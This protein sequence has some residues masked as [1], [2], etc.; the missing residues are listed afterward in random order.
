MSRRSNRRGCNADACSTA[1]KKTFDSRR[2]MK[3]RHSDFKP[4]LAKRFLTQCC[5]FI[6]ANVGDDRNSGETRDCPLQTFA[7]LERRLGKFTTVGF[8][9]KEC[10]T[11]GHIVEIRYMSDI[12]RSDP[13]NFTN[14]V[15]A[16][17]N[18]VVRGD[19]IV[20]LEGVIE[21]VIDK[22]RQ[23]NQPW[24]IRAAGLAARTTP[25]EGANAGFEINTYLGKM[26]LITSGQAKGSRAFIMDDFY[27]PDGNIIPGAV[28]MSEWANGPFGEP[29]G[30]GFLFPSGPPAPGDTFQVLDFYQF[31]LGN[32]VVG[33]HPE[34]SAVGQ[35]PSGEFF[36]IPGGLLFQEVHSRDSL[37][38][39]LADFENASAS[40]CDLS[41]APSFPQGIGNTSTVGG[42]VD[43]IIDT[44]ISVPPTSNA[45]SFNTLFRGS[46]T[47]NSGGILTLGMGGFLNYHSE[48]YPGGMFVQ[49]GGRVYMDGDPVFMG[50]IERV[51]GEGNPS[52]L[53]ADIQNHG[54]ITTGPI[55]FWNTNHGMVA[56]GGGY[57]AFE[58]F[59]PLYGESG[60][61]PFWG[62]NNLQI[63]L[64]PHGE[65]YIDQFLD[66]CGPSVIPTFEAGAFGT[67]PF[68]PILAFLG[69]R[70]EFGWAIDPDTQLPVSPPGGI[71]T[72][73]ADLLIPIPAGFQ[74]CVEEFGDGVVEHRYSEILKPNTFA[75]LH[76]DVFAF[77]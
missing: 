42:F 45:T 52:P 58:A 46:L 27:D 47:V 49:H 38:E 1:C 44:R 62:N 20:L 63:F 10:C 66:N 23:I 18:V 8:D 74:V 3:K 31:T 72:N 64:F 76:F 77:C 2:S 17:N 69:C 37:P 15:A 53:F 21:E 32:V 29:Q 68:A 59:T 33:Y 6:D 12:P 40:P 14:Y 5:W 60:Y 9:D 75:G 30:D 51:D 67:D 7:E 70:S 43:S 22:D 16:G 56:F 19:R 61:V 41:V 36:D 24:V 28:H 35:Q 34:R 73:W 54:L 71:L 48:D 4:S 25:T 65:I 26:V 55:S 13:F 39:N 50:D 11:V 57:Y